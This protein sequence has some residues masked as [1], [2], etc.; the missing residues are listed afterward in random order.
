MRHTSP[1]ARVSHGGSGNTAFGGLP[2]STNS[3][4][5]GPGTY[6]NVSVGSAMNCGTEVN[7]ITEELRMAVE[8]CQ[9]M[10]Y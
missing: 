9:V 4:V 8:Q 1:A 5:H 10:R 7:A 2:T 3:V 6:P